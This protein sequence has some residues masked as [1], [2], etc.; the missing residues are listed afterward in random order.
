MIEVS[1]SRF[2][3]APPASVFAALADPANLAGI[4]PRVRRVELLEQHPDHA[5]V[6]THMALGPFGAIRNEGEVRWQTDRAIVFSSRRPVPVEARWSL[7][8]RGAGTDLQV[9][10]LLDLAALIGPLA[11]FVPAGEV[12]KLV[13]PDLEAALAAVAE[14]TESRS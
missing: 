11:A 5:R 2:V 3:A 6:A 14:R 10:L 4:I 8:P 9:Q 12:A 7:A 1:R 13:G